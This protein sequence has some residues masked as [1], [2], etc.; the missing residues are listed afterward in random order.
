MRHIPT[1]KDDFTIYSDD[2]GQYIVRGAE[3]WY[4]TIHPVERVTDY[5]PDWADK[6]F[7]GITIIVSIVT[8]IVAT[9]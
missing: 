4:I 6:L 1:G 8:I 7:L 5:Y 9:I 2:V 3:K